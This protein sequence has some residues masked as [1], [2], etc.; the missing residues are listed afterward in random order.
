MIGDHAVL[1]AFIGLV[2]ILVPIPFLA[3]GLLVCTVQ[4]MVFVLLSIIYIALA[5]EDAHH[6]D[7]HHGDGRTRLNHRSNNF[8]VIVQDLN[9]QCDRE[10]ERSGGI[11]TRRGT[12]NGVYYD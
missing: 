12:N 1:G 4:T 2:P 7:H 10:R 6:D 9:A 5:V 8:N 11:T 3:L